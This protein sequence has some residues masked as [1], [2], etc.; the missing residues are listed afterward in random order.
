MNSIKKICIYG[1]IVLFTASI[2]HDLF[3]EE[4]HSTV[5]Q[6]SIDQTHTDVLNVKVSEDDSILSIVK[7]INTN[8]LNVDTKQIL[9]DFKHANPTTKSTEIKAGLYYYFP[10]YD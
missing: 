7:K 2:S 8:E 3:K 6:S 5:S 9:L 1:L 4:V 10:L